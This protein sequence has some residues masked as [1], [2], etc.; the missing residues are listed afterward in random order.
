M[1]LFN[2]TLLLNVTSFCLLKSK[3]GKQVVITG[4]QA[5]ALC[6]MVKMN[7]RE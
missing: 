2:I 7:S 5:M 3:E 4:I 6:L 1:L